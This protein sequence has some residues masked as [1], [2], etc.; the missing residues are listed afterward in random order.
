MNDE[1][2]EEM[3]ALQEQQIKTFS[4]MVRLLSILE[5]QIRRI[6]FRLAN[7]EKDAYARTPMESISH[8]STETPENEL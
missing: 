8:G 4:R 6:E 2:P 1:I 3:I 5:Q 7:L